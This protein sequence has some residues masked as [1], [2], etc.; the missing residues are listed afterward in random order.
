VSLVAWISGGGCLLLGLA[1]GYLFGRRSRDQADIQVSA[2]DEIKAVVAAD[3]DADAIKAE[4]AVEVAAVSSESP[5]E[6]IDELKA[7]E[8][9]S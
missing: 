4:T 6:I 7:Q 1:V 8:P 9:K 2:K 3:K 5:E